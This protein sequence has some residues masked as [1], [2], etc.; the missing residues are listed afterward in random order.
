MTKR[1]TSFGPIDVAFDDDF[2]LAPRPWTLLQ[3]A[4]AVD[5][6]RTGTAGTILELHCGAGHIGQAAAAW[7]GLSIVQ[8][9]D[10]PTCCG[11]AFDNAA[12]NGIRSLVVC[13]STNALP[14]APASCALVIA[15]PPYVASPEIAK[16]PEDP[17]HSIDGG[18][19]G[20]DGVRATLA[21]VA[22]LLRR[23]GRLLLQVRGPAQAESASALAAIAHP[24]LHA[25]GVAVA[26]DD[27]AVVEL[28]RT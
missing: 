18:D 17:R 19:D 28:L 4:M 14:V 13:A 10:E 9:D 6:A 7:L 12:R 8:V 25:V 24:E 22:P 1:R 15:D 20:L 27:R 11:W 23:E 2:V 26:A 16:Y 21:A 3:S 5:R